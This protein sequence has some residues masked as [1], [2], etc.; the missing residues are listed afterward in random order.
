MMEDYNSY[1]KNLK[2]T[3]ELYLLRNHVKRVDIRNMPFMRDKK[4]I[5]GKYN[6]IE[7]EH[8]CGKTF[9]INLIYDAYLFGKTELE[10]FPEIGE[11][12]KIN[13]EISFKSF[14]EC[15]Y[16]F[17]EKSDS[18]DT[19]G[20]DEFNEKVDICF[21]FDEPTKLYDKNERDGFLDYLKNVDGQ[22][23]IA[24]GKDEN[25]SYPKEYKIIKI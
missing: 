22:M 24:S 11:Y 8:G 5:F 12:S 10:F 6:I 2:L 7:G 20:Y 18:I 21:I 25:Y 15:K 3:E 13:A 4:I 17:P 9:L 14:T 1:I 16:T 19:L 23:I